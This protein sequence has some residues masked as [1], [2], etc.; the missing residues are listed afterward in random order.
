MSMRIPSESRKQSK[1]VLVN[2]SFV[3]QLDLVMV[4]R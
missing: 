4:I 3:K 2:K 1:S